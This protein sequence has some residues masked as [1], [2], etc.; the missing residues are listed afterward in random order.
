MDNI[1]CI[2][3]T[4][5][6][7]ILGPKLGRKNYVDHRVILKKFKDKAKQIYWT[8]SNTFKY[9]MGTGKNSPVKMYNSLIRS[10][11]DYGSSI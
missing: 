8:L 2:A 9:K 11:L 10:I 3:Y 7:N 1:K 4:R 6:I 5:R